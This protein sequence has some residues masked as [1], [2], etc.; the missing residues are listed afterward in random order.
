VPAGLPLGVVI[1]VQL[2]RETRS[3]KNHLYLDR[4]RLYRRLAVRDCR[5]NTGGSRRDPG[6]TG[7]DK[8]IADTAGGINAE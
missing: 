3:E 2:Y 8:A 7:A 1:S 5:S 6:Q 4:R